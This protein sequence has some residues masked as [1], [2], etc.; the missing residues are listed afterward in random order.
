VNLHT[1]IYFKNQPSTETAYVLT[2]SADRFTVLVPKF[3]IEGGI[4]CSDVLKA[5]G[6]G[7]V[8][9]DSAAH[10]L[11]FVRPA[12]ASSG[13]KQP[14]VGRKVLLSLQVF[15]KV[16]VSIAVKEDNNDKRLVIDLIHGK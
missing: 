5:L 4:E 14:A 11:V 7:E 2:V 13:K 16:E 9:Y 12:Q 1:L 10:K 6:G 3:G 8:E 15:E